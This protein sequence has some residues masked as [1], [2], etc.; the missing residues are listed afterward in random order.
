MVALTFS[1]SKDDEPSSSKKSSIDLSNLE[2]GQASTYRQY[3]TNCGNLNGD[4]QYTGD[5]MVVEVIESDGSLYFKEYLTSDSPSVIGGNAQDPVIHKVIVENGR[6]LIPERNLSPVFY[7]YGNDTIHLNPQPEVNLEQNGCVLQTAPGSPFIGNEIG[8]VD[9]F[10]IGQVSQSDK[11]AVSCVPVILDLEAYLI[12][13]SHKL[14]IS[15]TM[16]GFGGI[17]NGWELM[18]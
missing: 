10:K 13:D 8:L 17:I 14:Y 11:I 1:C 18:E 6:I 15:H 2:V 16:T 3:Y 12:Y 5:K 7:F 9:D 4:F